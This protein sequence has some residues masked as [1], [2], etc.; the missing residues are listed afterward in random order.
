MFI[1][2]QYKLLHVSVC[3]RVEIMKHF[4]R[5]SSLWYFRRVLLIIQG[6]ISDPEIPFEST[7]GMFALLVSMCTR[8]GSIRIG[9]CAF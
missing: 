1:Q 5:R 3:D 6:M 2:K 8:V 7:G 9:N 4:L